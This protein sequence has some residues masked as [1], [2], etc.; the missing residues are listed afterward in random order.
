MYPHHL[1]GHESEYTQFPGALVLDVDFQAPRGLGGFS[2]DE[3]NGA[4][5]PGEVGMEEGS[6]DQVVQGCRF[7]DDAASG[8]LGG[9]EW[10]EL[11]QK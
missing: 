11:A 8:V 5:E 2:D 6:Q 4:Y 9:A 7:L 10:V 3:E 1:N